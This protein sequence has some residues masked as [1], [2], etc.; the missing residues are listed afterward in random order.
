MPVVKTQGT[1]LYLAAGSPIAVMTLTCPT[2]IQGLGGA[3][4]QIDST[5]L[6]N[7]DDKT[8]EGGLGNP[9][10]VTVPFNFHPN[11]ADQQELF[12]L[13]TSGDKISWLIGF[14]DGITA[15]TLDSNDALQA[16]PAADRTSALFT[17]YVADVAIDIATNDIVKGTLTLQRSGSVA[18]TWKTA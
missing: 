5:C 12:D 11:A 2:G 1:K 3:R 4:D 14:S 10:Q 9:G 18:W 15:P 13:K 7:I 6:D 17:A 16:P 8:F